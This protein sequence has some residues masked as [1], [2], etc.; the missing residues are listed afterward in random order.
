MS[1]IVSTSRG[2]VVGIYVLGN[3]TEGFGFM[4]PNGTFT[5]TPT[6]SGTFAMWFSVDIDDRGRILGF[7]E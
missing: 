2:E 7:Y 3:L 4:Y 5:D 6:S 1:L